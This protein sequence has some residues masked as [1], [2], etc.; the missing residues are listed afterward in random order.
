MSACYNPDTFRPSNTP[1]LAKG[2][3][4]M[5]QLFLVDAASLPLTTSAFPDEGAIPIFRKI[6]DAS[7]SFAATV[8]PKSMA[9]GSALYNYGQ[10]SEATFSAAARLLDQENP[11]RTLLSKL[12][13][14]LSKTAA[15]N[16]AAASDLF[17]GTKA[18]VDELSRQEPLLVKL[19][20]DE[21]A[22]TGGLQSQIDPLNTDIKAQRAILKAAQAAITDDQ[23][24]IHDT[25][26]YSWIP[27]IGAIVALGEVIAHQNDIQTQLQLIQAAVTQIEADNRKLQPLQSRMNQLIYAQNFNNDQIRQVL[28]VTPVLQK[29]EGAWSTIGHELAAVL[30]QISSAQDPGSIPCLAQVALTT[31]ANEWH[32]IANDAHNYMTNFYITAPASAEP[33]GPRDEGTVESIDSLTQVVTDR[34]RVVRMTRD[35]QWETVL[36]QRYVAPRGSAVL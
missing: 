35:R 25:V 1:L 34:R 24:V 17:A 36:V 26:Y 31:A 33:A 28:E 22:S 23:K 9:T 4:S 27:F 12:F 3:W 5:V 2:Q 8:L 10:T 6:H 30:G 14:S 11:D 7:A 29:I 19:V 21:V 15:D 32:D 16:Q 20:T 18:F 13:G